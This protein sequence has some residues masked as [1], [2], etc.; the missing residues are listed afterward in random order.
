MTAKRTVIASVGDMGAETAA[1]IA[2]SVTAA[3]MS[4]TADGT[5]A[6]ATRAATEPAGRKT[7]N[8]ATALDISR[9]TNRAGAL[10]A[11]ATLAARTRRDTTVDWVKSR[12]QSAAMAGTMVR[13]DIAAEMDRNASTKGLIVRP[14][15]V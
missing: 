11:A 14:I 7:T 8:A 5:S 3:R 10:P 9:A 15:M 13:Q 6:A 12:H 1:D 2:D 4:V